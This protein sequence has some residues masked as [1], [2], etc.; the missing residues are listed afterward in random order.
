MMI[1]VLCHYIRG[2]ERTL[3]KGSS[4]VVAKHTFMGRAEEAKTSKEQSQNNQSN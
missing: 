2:A 4:P 3:F 1:R